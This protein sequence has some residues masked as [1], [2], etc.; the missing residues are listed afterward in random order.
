MM[1][2]FCDMNIK[3]VFVVL[4][5]IVAIIVGSTPVLAADALYRMLH[6]DEVE[7]FREEQ[8]AFIVGQL[9]DKKGDKYQ[10]KIL[11]V[12][13]GKMN[14]DTFLLADDFQY[15]YGK[16]DF[17]PAINDYCVMSL[18]KTGDYYKRAWGIFKAT[19]GD[20]KTLKLLS[21]DIKYSVCNGDVA[22]VEW[23][24]NS[25]GMENDFSFVREKVFVRRVDGQ[26]LQIYP[27]EEA[28]EVTETAVGNSTLKTEV[29][30]KENKQPEDVRVN[31][32]NEFKIKP[33]LLAG[34]IVSFVLVLLL[35]AIKMK[36]RKPVH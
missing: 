27:K 2:K 8:D 16:V 5:I 24:V 4:I 33:Q 26:N 32:H 11:K 23:Y 10:V 7:Q 22:A 30:D 13:S 36:R 18:K 1:K 25:G 34:I 6:A 17:N 35:V 15:G 29:A 28:G 19:S 14:A 3:R 9:V 31:Q 21:E 20:Y 12:I